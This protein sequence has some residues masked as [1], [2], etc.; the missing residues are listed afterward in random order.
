MVKLVVIIFFFFE[1]VRV[2]VYW[3]CWECVDCVEEGV[4][5]YFLNDCVV[6]FFCFLEGKGVVVFFESFKGN[7]CEEEL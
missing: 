4:E 6:E 7:D 2:D 3:V 5:C 1:F